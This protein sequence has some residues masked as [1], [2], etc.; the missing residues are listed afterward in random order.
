MSDSTNNRQPD[1]LTVG[2]VFGVVVNP[3][4]YRNILYLTLAF[5]L[6]TL[7]FVGLTF[8]LALG[9]GL[10]V[11]FVGIP[12]L[13]A[14]VLG[15]RPVSTFER[16]L[17][18]ELLAVEISPPNDAPPVEGEQFW[19]TLKRYLGAG[20][21]WKGLVFLYLKFWIG[22]FSFVILVV[23]ATVTGAFITAP[24]H[25]NDPAVSIG[26]GAWVIDSLPEALFGVVFGAAFGITSLHFFNAIAWIS[27]LLAKTLLGGREDVNEVSREGMRT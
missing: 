6:G 17:A 4:T 3:Q 23:G 1:R 13:I 20:S 15:S 19:Q 11:V 7:Y 22:L 16:I 2:D 9:L 18:N 14:V 26:V 21:T 12:I 25:Y 27:G 10:A 24:L 5:P 8:G